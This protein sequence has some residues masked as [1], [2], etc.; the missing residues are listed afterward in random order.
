MTYCT[1]L[2]GQCLSL[3]TCLMKD[4][5]DYQELY[6]PDFQAES[7]LPPLISLPQ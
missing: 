1:S 5:K 7:L 4:N 6:F 3:S 2:L